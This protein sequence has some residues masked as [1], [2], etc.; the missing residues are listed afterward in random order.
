MQQQERKG[1]FMI[2]LY[3]LKRDLLRILIFFSKFPKIVGIR[4]NNSL[5]K[6]GKITG[7][8]QVA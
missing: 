8:I 1:S 2:I 6:G 5:M 3:P 4:Y 7:H